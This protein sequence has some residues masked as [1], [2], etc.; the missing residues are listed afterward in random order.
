MPGLAGFV[1]EGKSTAARTSLAAMGALLRHADSYQTDELFDDGT[2]CATRCHTGLLQAQPQ[3][4]ARQGRYLWLDGELYNRAEIDPQAATD[5]QLLLD[6][7]LQDGFKSFAQ[8]DGLYTAVLYDPPT[9]Q[10]HLINNRYG[11]RPLYWTVHRGRLTWAS[12]VKALLALP[13]F[14][15]QLDREALE[16]FLAVGY[17]DGDRTWF[18]GIQRLPGAAVLSWDLQTHSHHLA[19]YWS[20]SDVPPLDGHPNP[21]DLAAELGGLFKDAVARRWRDQQRVGLVLSGGLDSRAILAAAPEPPVSATFGHPD[22]ADAR[23]AARAAHRKGADHHLLELRAADWLASRLDAVWWTDGMLDILHM[24]GVETFAPLKGYFDIALNGA[25]GDG[26]VGGG[27]LFAEDQLDIHLQN[28]LGLDPT[29]WPEVYG[30]LKEQF[31]RA[32][33]AHAFYIDHRMRSFTV[34]GPLMGTFAGLEYRLPFLDNAFQEKLFA[35]PTPL[36]QGNRLYRRLLLDAFPRFFR[37][38][39]WAATGVP[40][41]WPA[42]MGR[43]VRGGRR[44]LGRR[45]G[46]TGVDYA[47]WLRQPPARDWIATCLLDRDALYLEY[48]DRHQ[49]QE[50]WEAH[51]AGRDRTVELGRYMTVEIFLQQVL[52]RRWRPGD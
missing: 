44:V 19:S 42:W 35:I 52:A 40:L 25:G 47:A 16:S 33:S 41:A 36:K 7:Y 31:A 26:L 43:L 30:R 46:S 11:L 13:A 1:G 24:H 29:Q 38:I 22:S 5:L 27:H 12:E 28:R 3:P 32:G 2:I 9:H 15:P 10:L 48:L 6:L 39:P 4:C 51:L 20:W 14:T 49:V 37:T 50:T 45:A 8:L 17:L 18:E 23:L 34:Y 21:R